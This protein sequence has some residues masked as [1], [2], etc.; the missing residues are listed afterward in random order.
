MLINI[1]AEIE[2][3]RVDEVLNRLLLDK[4][5]GKNILWATEAYTENGPAFERNAEIQ[6][7]LLTGLY[8]GMVDTRAL[9]SLP[10][11]NHRTKKHAEV[12]TPFYLCRAMNAI[13]DQSFADQ[14]PHI[15]AGFLSEHRMEVQSER[16]TES[17]TEH[18]W[19]S[20]V[21]FRVMEMTCGE[22]PFLVS[23]YDVANGQYIRLSDRIGLLDRKLQLI[24]FYTSS[25]EDWLKWTKRAFQATYGFEFQGD[26]LL[27]ARL[28]LYMSFVE[29][30]QARWQRMPSYE[31]SRSICHIIAW[32][33]WQM[34]G[35][36]GAI[37]YKKVSLNDRQIDF[38]TLLGE[39]PPESSNTRCRIYDWR[40]HKT[41]EYNSLTG[42]A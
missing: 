1:P 7:D 38:F 27:L 22:G 24:S 25:E 13:L 9:K 4:S 20:Y 12:F 17:V 14:L 29:Y 42:R 5:T 19:K 33:I 6:A 15:S 39:T 11:Q 21:D 26:S 23:R 2:Q 30:L 34:D 40:S 36:T 8:H 28:N 18:N 32:N 16:L 10:L 31:E 3:A 37:P 35:L 41:M